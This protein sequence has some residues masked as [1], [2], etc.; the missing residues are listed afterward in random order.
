MSEFFATLRP[1]LAYSYDNIF[2]ILNFVGIILMIIGLQ[3]VRAAQMKQDRDAIAQ[4]KVIDWLKTELDAR[5]PRIERIEHIEQKLDQ[6]T[7]GRL[8]D[9]HGPG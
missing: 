3:Y 2:P 6:L 4:R 9:D 7:D 1:Y 8:K 5:G